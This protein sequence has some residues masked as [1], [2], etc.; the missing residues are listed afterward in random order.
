MSKW[1]AAE[2]AYSVLGNAV[3]RREYV[4]GFVGVDSGDGAGVGGVQ[5][6]ER[7]GA[8]V[9]KGGKGIKRRVERADARDL[10]EGEVVENLE[11]KQRG[12][13]RESNRKMVGT[14]KS[15]RRQR[16]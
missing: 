15:E 5:G 1:Y 7:A 11:L 8:F 10:G 4:G 6:W 13:R 9:E 3:V 12:R 2:R 16:L 14:W